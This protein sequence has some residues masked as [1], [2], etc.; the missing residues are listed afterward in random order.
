MITESVPPDCC[1][2]VDAQDGDRTSTS[3]ELSCDDNV[4]DSSL[5]RSI[6]PKNGVFLRKMRLTSGNGMVRSSLLSSAK[7][8]KRICAWQTDAESDGEEKAD[9]A[10]GVAINEDAVDSDSALGEMANFPTKGPCD[11]AGL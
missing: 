7:V 2:L 9:E 11:N 8:K 10:N 6:S 4:G 1:E 3:S 5:M